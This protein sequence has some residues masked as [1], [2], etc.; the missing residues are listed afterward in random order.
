MQLKKNLLWFLFEKIDIKLKY[1]LYP[2]KSQDFHM[3]L[4]NRKVM[5][6]V[7]VAKVSYPFY[8]TSAPVLTCVGLGT[9]G[10]INLVGYC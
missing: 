5:V 3:H 10:E 6:M 9:R 8:L 1:R 7:M 4:D 2:F